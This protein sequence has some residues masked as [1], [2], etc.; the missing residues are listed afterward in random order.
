MVL[1]IQQ[2]DIVPAIRVEVA[3][4]FELN[5]KDL[6]LFLIKA[7]GL[8]Q[9]DQ[10][11]G[12]QNH[13]NI[14]IRKKTNEK[15]QISIRI[16]LSSVNHCME[17]NIDK[18]DFIWEL[19]YQI[20][21]LDNSLPATKQRLIFGGQQLDDFKTLSNYNIKDGFVLHLVTKISSAAI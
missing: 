20:Y 8:S 4:Q 2:L 11:I 14:L 1:P 10:L 17:I 5:W 19:K 13:S 15:M 6:N 12:I 3:R 9:K 7:K 16:I 18:N 21:L